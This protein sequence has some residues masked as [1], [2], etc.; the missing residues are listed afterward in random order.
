MFFEIKKSQYKKEN[1]KEKSRKWK[2]FKY[3]IFYPYYILKLIYLILF[4]IDEKINP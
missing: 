1:N 4:K 2:I 3:I